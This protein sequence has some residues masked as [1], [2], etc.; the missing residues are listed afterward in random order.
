MLFHSLFTVSSNV[1]SA[2]FQLWGVV[3]DLPKDGTPALLILTGIHFSPGFSYQGVSHTEFETHVGG[4]D[5]KTGGPDVHA[6]LVTVKSDEE[7]LKV[8]SFGLCFLP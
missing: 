7:L 4:L 6:Q 8:L 5:L 2:N 3:G 1:Y